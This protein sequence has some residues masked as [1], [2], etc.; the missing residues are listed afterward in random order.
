MLDQVL[1]DFHPV[2]GVELQHVF[3]QRISTALTLLAFRFNLQLFEHHRM[4][5]ANCLR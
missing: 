1:C 4:Q 2:I 3:R 5:L